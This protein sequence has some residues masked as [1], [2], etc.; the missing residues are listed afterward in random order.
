M[1]AEQPRAQV[2]PPAPPAAVVDCP[3]V[4]SLPEE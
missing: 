3:P 1:Y 4:Q 2:E